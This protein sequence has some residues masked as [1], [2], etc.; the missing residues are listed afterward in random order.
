MHKVV[1]TSAI[2]ILKCN[3]CHI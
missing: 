2:A 1:Y 3:N